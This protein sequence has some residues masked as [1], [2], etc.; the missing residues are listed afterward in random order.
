M[1]MPWKFQKTLGCAVVISL[2]LA[3]AQAQSVEELQ[4]RFDRETSAVSK[5]KLLVKLGDAQFEE[6]RKAGRE[7]DNNT[8][9]LTMEKYRDNV[10][11]AFEALKKQHPDAEKHSNGYRQ[12]EMHVE[13][14]IREVQDTILAAPVP[15]KPPLQ[16]VRQDLIAMDD[17]LIRLLFPH[18]PAQKK[19]ATPSA[20]KQP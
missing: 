18:R 16:I 3:P 20:E 12:L 15:Y 13:G 5:A 8:V 6:A 17:E 2:M 1:R 4:A 9:G 10:R 7:G 11:A 19:P 14:A